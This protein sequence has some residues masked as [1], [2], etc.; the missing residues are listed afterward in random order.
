MATEPSKLRISELDFQQIKENFKEFLR[1]Q[2]E[3]RDYNFD[4]SVIS[5]LLDLLSYNTHYNSYYLNMIA[6][7]MFIDSAV[8]RTSMVSLAK[9]IGY[10]PRSRLGA[11]ANVNITVTPNDNPSNIVISK[12]TKFNSQIDGVNFLFV[13][14]RS[15]TAFANNQNLAVTIPNVTL[16]E[17]EPLSYRYTVDGQNDNQKFVI[18]NRGVDHTTISVVVQESSTDTRKSS[19]TLATD[20]LDV[21]AS[22]N[23]Y[24]IEETSDFKTEI[25]FGDGVLG[26]KLKNQNI[27]LVNYNLCS[28]ALANRANTFTVATTAGGYDTVTVRTNTP[29]TGGADEESLNSIRFN[30]PKNYGVQNRAVTKNDYQ[31]LIQRDYPYAESVVIYGGEDSDPPEFGKVFIGIK[32]REGLFLSSSIKETII[33]NIVG[34]Y[35]VASITP[36]F[37]DIDYVNLVLSSDVKYD[38][39]LTVKTAQILKKNVL[40]AIQK[41]KV[42]TLNQFEQTFR[43]SQ[44]QRAIDDAEGAILGNDTEIEIKKKLTPNLTVQ[45]DYLI[46]F[47]N[48]LYH[49]YSNFMGTLTSTAFTYKDDFEVVRTD[50]RFDDDNGTLRIYRISD[51]QKIIINANAGTVDYETGRV[52]ILTFKPESYQ[53]TSLDIIVKPRNNDFQTK[54][55]QILLIDEN[56]I[57]LSFFDS[58]TTVSNVEV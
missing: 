13:T 6:N 33:N 55:A 31:R 25:V 3:F 34:K 15:Y 49:P 45:L 1:N 53:G 5:T 28:G 27:V 24:F 40:S 10:T 56:D 38:S 43:I 4:G 37:V 42:N 30:A 12:N 54:N 26:N 50:C 22:S 2:D 16:V 44:L 29:A 51:G 39:R 8:T 48:Q 14:D 21:G 23:V 9:M 52:L 17:G 35:N 19:Y 46:N 11:R 58:S 41:Y 7:E 18:P 57:R 36:E 32:P 47:N 20:L